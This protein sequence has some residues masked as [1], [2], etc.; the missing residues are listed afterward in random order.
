MVLFSWLF[1]SLHFDSRFILQT[2]F[3]HFRFE[4]FRFFCVCIYS[5]NL[6]VPASVCVNTIFL[7]TNIL[8]FVFSLKQPIKLL[9][10]NNEKNTSEYIISLNAEAEERI[11]WNKNWFCLS[12]LLVWNVL[13]IHG[14]CTCTSN[15]FILWW[16]A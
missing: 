2:H 10:E 8:H 3:S 12:L 13:C 6:C 14:V 1:L 15:C 16:P 9:M 4:Q 11:E 7:W 5:I